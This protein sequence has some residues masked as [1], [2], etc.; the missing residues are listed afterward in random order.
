MRKFILSLVLSC[1][2]AFGLSLSP[3][4]ATGV[5]DLP[6]LGAGSTTYILD[7]ASAISAANEGKLNRDFQQLA[8]K[9]GNEVRMVVVRRLDYGQKIDNLAD[10][11]FKEW[12][13]TPEDR[14]EQ[15]LI[16][17][18]TLT[19]KTAIRVGD[20]TGALLTDEI[21]DS[22]ISETMAAPL[23]DGAKY[24]QALLDAGRRLT[25]VLSGETD[26]GP[27]AEQEVNIAS[28]FT[29]AEDTDDKSATV[30]VI[31]LLVLA[32]AIP[33]ATYFWYAGFGR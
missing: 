13:S 21:A 16:V 15:T 18:D 19:N 7:N 17:I 31:V 11:I 22:V 25:A 5:Y 20:K 2:F 26:P 9:T 4:G 30:W 3:A 24:N 23:K 32:T 1:L 12:Y 28:T 27:P 33:M 10:D 29:S 14:A 6:V 8:E